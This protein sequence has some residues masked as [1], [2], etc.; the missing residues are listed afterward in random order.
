MSRVSKPKR[1]K[2]PRLTLNAI[3]KPYRLQR[4]VEVAR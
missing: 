2:T 4:L 1:P 3:G